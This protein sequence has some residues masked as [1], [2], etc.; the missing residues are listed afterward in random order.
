MI[1]NAYEFIEKGYAEHF[2]LEEWPDPEELK[3]VDYKVIENLDKL[4]EAH[5]RAIIP[6]QHPDGLIRT[7]GSKTSRHYV[8]IQRREM[9][10]AVDVFPKGDVRDCW[11]KA[12][13][14]PEWGGIGVYLD[15]N[16]NRNQPGPMMHLDIDFRNG[17]RSFWVRNKGKYI[18]LADEPNNFWFF[19]AK[20]V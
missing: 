15:T 14:N 1:K 16:R 10:E 20:A 9:G 6:S 17:N 12:V 2:S 3:Y 5:G 19:L 13:E 18:Y 8:D 7:S 4:R 11:I